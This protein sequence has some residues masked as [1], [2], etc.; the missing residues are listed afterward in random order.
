MTRLEL[1]VPPPAVALAATGVMTLLSWLPGPTLE[2]ATTSGLQ[3]VAPVLASVGIGI[4]VAGVLSFRHAR[5][6]VNP[7]KPEGATAL[8][9]SGIYRLTRNPMYLGLA[10]VLLGWSAWLGSPWP[11]AGIAG[12]VAWITRFQILPEERVLTR[13]FGAQFEAYC[14]RVRRWL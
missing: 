9:T 2:P 13:L 5:T 11:L 14:G 4:A 3:R 10:V 1:K 8:V 7:L 12:F 6:T